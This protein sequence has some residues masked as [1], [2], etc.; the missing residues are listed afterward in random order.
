MIGT[1]QLNVVFVASTA[2]FLVVNSDFPASNDS[3]ASSGRSPASID[4]PASNVSPVSNAVPA[5]NVF[6]VDSN[7]LANNDCPASNDAHWI[8]KYSMFTFS[9][10]KIVQ[11]KK[12]MT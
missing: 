6:P 2:I 5:S 12:I 7:S 10:E 3:P 11:K 4:S 1:Y 8:Y 9:K